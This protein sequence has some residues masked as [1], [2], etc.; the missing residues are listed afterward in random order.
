[1]HPDFYAMLYVWLLPG[2]AT[3][4]FDSKGKFLA[5]EKK[6]SEY[7]IPNTISVFCLEEISNKFKRKPPRRGRPLYRDK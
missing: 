2:S 5:M 6:A 1:M 3:V 7:S 4:K